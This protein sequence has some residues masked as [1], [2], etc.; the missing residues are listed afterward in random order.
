MGNEIKDCIIVSGAPE[1]DLSFLKSKISK[2]SYI[3]CADSGY[4]KCIKIGVLPDLIIGDFDSSPIPEVECEIV[5]LNPEKAFSDT[6]HCVIEACDRG[7]KNITILGAI[8]DRVDHSYANILCLNYCKENGVECSIINENNRISLIT[9]EKRI[10]KDYDN[11]SLF[12][13]L[14]PCKGVRIDGAYYTAGFYS[15]QALDFNLS[16]QIGV[17]NYVCDEFATISL[18]KGTLLLIESN[19]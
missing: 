9:S 8:G 11:F 18:E 2:D 6:F 10:F 17:S 3:I 1:K 12:A 16:D 5:K 7:Y 15:K 14:E 13:F 19:D 4:E